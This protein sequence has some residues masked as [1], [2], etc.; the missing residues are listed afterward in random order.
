MSGI[1]NGYIPRDSAVHKMNPVLKMLMFIAFVILVFLPVGLVWQT[2]I[3]IVISAIFF[4][5]KLPGH[6][7][8]TNFKSVAIMFC[9]LIFINWFT[10]RDP[11]Y[12]MVLTAPGVHELELKSVSFVQV[13][14]YH[15]QFLSRTLT[16]T[17]FFNT[18]EFHADGGGTLA[19]TIQ[20]VNPAVN[21]QQVSSY[22]EFQQQL[23]AY[24]LNGYLSNHALTI[25]RYA[26]AKLIGFDVTVANNS[27]STITPVFEYAGYAISL[28]ALVM[29]V[30]ITQ[31]IFVMI[32]LAVILTSTSTSIELSYAIERLLVPFKLFKLPVN[33][34]AMTISVAIRFV[35]SLLLESQRILNAQAARGI[36]FKNGHAAE[37]ARALVSLVVPMVSIAFRNAADI[38][39]AMET[40]AYNPRYARTRY[41]AFAIHTRDWIV[42]GVLMLALGFAIAVA[43]YRVYFAFFGAV[44]WITIGPG[45]NTAELTTSGTSR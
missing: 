39:N 9:V 26:G 14:A 41:R 44:D 37:R 43:A 2:L 7:Y 25:S 21:N 11:G 29:S 31:K 5:A 34:L 40:R 28:R 10:Y 13:G 15:D 3:W 42:Y 20:G 38:S 36:D 27:I 1:I 30:F 4:V 24:N 33:A 32:L 45:Q 8:W 35:P 19:L 18:T 23:S 22:T 16:T 17:N 6:T 12:T